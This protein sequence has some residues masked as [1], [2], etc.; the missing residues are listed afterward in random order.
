MFLWKWTV[1]C[2][3]ARRFQ[4]WE[5]YIAYLNLLIWGLNEELHCVMGSRGLLLALNRLVCVGHMSVLCPLGLG[6]VAI[7]PI[8]PGMLSFFYY[9]FSTHTYVYIRVIDAFYCT[10]LEPLLHSSSSSQLCLFFQPIMY[11][12]TLFTTSPPFPTALP[13]WWE[14]S[15]TAV[16][17][18]DYETMYLMRRRL[19]L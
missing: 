13:A 9:I 8:T 14:T 15:W 18:V 5:N 3:P 12:V 16:P 17:G 4:R 10:P 2:K 1:C 7:T 11:V 19:W 6:G